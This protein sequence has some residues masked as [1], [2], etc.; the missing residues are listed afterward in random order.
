MHN[1]NIFMEH[2]SNRRDFLKKSGLL[3]LAGLSTLMLNDLGARE[4]G[5]AANIPEGDEV[6]TL[7]GLPYDYKALEPHVDAKTMEIHHSKHHQAYVTNLN[8][9]VKE[10]GLQQTSLEELCRGVSKHSAAVRNNGGGHYNHSFFWKL[11]K[12]NGGG[13]PGG[14]LA[15]AIKSSFG[16]FDAFRKKFTEAATSRF[17]SGWAW[18]VESNGKLLIGSTPNQDNP[19]MDVSDF[20]GKPLL[21]LDVWEHAYYLKYQNKRADYIQAWWN[22][23]NWEEAAKQLAAK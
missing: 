16:S 6:F 3:T 12:P 18:L 17:G 10:Q 7:P 4:D 21:A 5:S 9:A 11:M 13:E 14:A 23:V 8:K 19:L 15:E 1:D 22:T 2:S 20:K